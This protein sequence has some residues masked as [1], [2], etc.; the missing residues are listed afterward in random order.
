MSVPKTS[1]Q[2]SI[3]PDVSNTDLTENFL[4][5]YFFSLFLKEKEGLNCTDI[6]LVI[7]YCNMD[8]SGFLNQL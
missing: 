7:F 1:W 6:D 4:R 8:C 3:E 2:N 5:T